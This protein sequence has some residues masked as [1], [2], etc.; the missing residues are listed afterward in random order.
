VSRLITA[1]FYA[2]RILTHVEEGRATSQRSLSRELGI[3]LGFTNLLLRRLVRK[4]CIEIVKVRP[5][6]VRYL[7]TAA[8]IVE[9]VRLSHAYLDNSVQFYREARDRIREVFAALSREWTVPNGDCPDGCAEKR[10]GFYGAGELAEIGYIC[11]QDTDL[12]LVAVI[13]ECCSK[14]FFGVPVLAPCSL[15]AGHVDGEVFDR[16]VVMSFGDAD[17]L[18]PKIAALGVPS[19]RVIWL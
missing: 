16:L 14:R 6:H 7:I 9:K 11:L 12:K 18:R 5:N 1:D 10:I 4:G 19:D 17:V 2:R 3:A 8:G 13:D 15:E